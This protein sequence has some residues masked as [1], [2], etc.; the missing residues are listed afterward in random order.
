MGSAQGHEEARGVWWWRLVA[1][2][3]RPSGGDCRRRTVIRGLPAVARRLG[4]SIWE[5]KRA[6]EPSVR[7]ANPWP[8]LAPLGRLSRRSP[9]ARPNIHHGLA[10]RDP[11][12]R[13]HALF[14]ALLARFPDSSGPPG[15]SI[16][17][18]ERVLDRVLVLPPHRAAWWCGLE[19]RA[20]CRVGNPHYCGLETRTASTTPHALAAVEALV[21]RGVADGDRPAHLA[22]RGV[23]LAIPHGD[24]E[25]R[26]L[27]PRLLD[28]DPAAGG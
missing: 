11:S 7:A 22:R 1:R 24:R 17:L 3:A 20:S 19:I 28:H 6:L 12:T 13:R 14:A 2:P 25:H 16:R 21:A 23:A 26:R 9:E 15:V 18:E 8:G 5:V 10:N 4:W 27:G